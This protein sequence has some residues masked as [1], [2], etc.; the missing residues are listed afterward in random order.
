MAGGQWR[1]TDR[2]G[3]YLA[4][5]WPKS[6]HSHT[7]I[8]AWTHTHTHTHAH[9]YRDSHTHTHA[10]SPIHTVVFKTV[11]WGP[12]SASYWMFW[13]LVSRLQSNRF[14][15]SRDDSLNWLGTWV[16]PVCSPWTIRLC[17]TR[18][19]SPNRPTTTC[20]VMWKS[21]RPFSDF[22][23]FY[24]FFRLNFIRFSTKTKY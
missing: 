4:P 16:M 21:I 1:E 11:L 2:L 13:S 17:C 18:V 6:R 15:S 7:H 10:H 9:R 3:W 8:H 24:T 23:Y 5:T 20:T 12:L 22:L 14:S 19:F